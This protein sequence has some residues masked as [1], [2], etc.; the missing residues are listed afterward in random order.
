MPKTVSAG[1]CLSIH[2][3]SPISIGAVTISLS[4]YLSIDLTRSL[5]IPALMLILN[6]WKSEVTW[7]YLPHLTTHLATFQLYDGN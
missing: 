2:P 5:L 6:C 4:D 3:S 7:T 1:A